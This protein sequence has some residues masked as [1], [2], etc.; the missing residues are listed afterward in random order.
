VLDPEIISL[1]ITAVVIGILTR[2]RGYMIFSVKGNLLWIGVFT[3]LT[4]RF[5]L[6]REYTTYGIQNTGLAFASAIILV[7]LIAKP[8]L[9][10]MIV[11]RASL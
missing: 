3:F 7:V 4:A 5:F 2:F 9:V 11:G 6:L 10:Q 8:D 1:I